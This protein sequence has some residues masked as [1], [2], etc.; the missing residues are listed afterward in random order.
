MKYF[1]YKGEREE[2]TS[3]YEGKKNEKSVYMGENKEAKKK[4]RKVGER[5]VVSK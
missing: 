1:Q 2:K 3:S 4:G 5:E